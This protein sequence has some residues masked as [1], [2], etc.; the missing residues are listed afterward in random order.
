MWA[1][2]P[3]VAKFSVA[4]ALSFH[5]G[6]LLCLVMWICSLA[7]GKRKKKK[8]EYK[9]FHS[10]PQDSLQAGLPPLRVSKLLS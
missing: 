1:P 3:K 10:H 9:R 2:K 6:D 4:W 8:L 5:L 7:G